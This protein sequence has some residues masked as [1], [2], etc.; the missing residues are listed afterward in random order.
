[1]HDAQP[2]PEQ[3]RWN[4][5]YRQ[6]GPNA[7]SGK[8]ARW[9]VDHRHLIEQLLGRRS[10]RRALDVAC[11]GGRHGLYLARL[12]FTVDA[13]DISDVAIDRLRDRVRRE[14]LAVD[15]RCGV[16]Q[17]EWITQDAGQT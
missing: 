13:L 6:Q 2:H 7:V 10:D 8:P 14:G 9:L 1:M 12:G 15:P 17:S 11:G 4:R 16:G 3:E 5:K